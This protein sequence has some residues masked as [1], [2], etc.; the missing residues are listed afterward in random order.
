MTTIPNHTDLLETA[1]DNLD[2]KQPRGLHNLFFVELWERFGFYCVQALLVLFL[3]KSFHFKDTQAYDLFSAASAL[4]Y[5]TPVIGG[6]LADKIL[7]YRRSVLFGGILFAIGYAL[8]ATTNPKLFYLALA[9]IICGNGFFKSCVSSLLGTLYHDNDPRR[10]SGFTLF[11]MGINLG[12]F[13]SPIICTWLAEQYGWGAGFSAASVGMIICIITIL[14]GFKIFGTRGLPPADIEKRRYFGLSPQTLVIFGVVA[15]L[16]LFTLL[17]HHSHLVDQGFNLFSII[18][19]IAIICISFRYQREQRNK[20]LALITLMFFSVLFWAVYTQIFTSL[21]LFTD[22]IVNRHFMNWTV[23]TA[24]FQSVNPFFIIALSPLLAILWLR[25]SGTRWELSAPGKFAL[26]M[27]LISAAFL[28]LPLGI[29]LAAK[30]GLVSMTWLNLNYFL[31]TCGELCLS[32]IGLSI[33]TTLAPAELTGMMMGV[34]FLCIADAYAL[35][36]YLADLTSVPSNITDPVTISHIYGHVYTKLGLATLLL[37]L[38]L[39]TLT[40]KLKRMMSTNTSLPTK[41]AEALSY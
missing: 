14:Y 25:T 31:L 23:P 20:M 15:T 18:T 3:I 37:S 5:A 8:L 33:V 2:R 12:S 9:L 13:I 34:W 38:I 27:L 16:G 1:K 39:M 6:Y 41:T 22:Q 19:F 4:M 7:G 11:Y 32:P 36:G 29:Q 40:P 10:D 28:V 17:V 24:M 35:G 21:T 30:N 26:A